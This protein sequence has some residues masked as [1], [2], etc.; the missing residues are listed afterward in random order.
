VKFAR[1]AAAPDFDAGVG[2]LLADFFTL[3]QR[4]TRLDAMLVGG[5]Q[6]DGGQTH[7]AAN[8]Q[9][10]RQVP[11]RG[12]VVRDDAEPITEGRRRRLCSLGLASQNPRCGPAEKIA[13]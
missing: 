2:K 3:R 8:L 1:G 11:R 5:A 4:Q 6:L 12:D 13:T 7:G 9:H 10:R